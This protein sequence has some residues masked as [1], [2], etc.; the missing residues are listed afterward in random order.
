MRVVFLTHNYP[1]RAGDASGAFLATLA[2]ALVRAGVD[3]RVVAPSHHGE[4]GDETLDGVSVRR[5][6][7]ATAT[8]ETIAYGA[9]ATALRRPGGWTALAGLWRA[10]RR[11]AREELAA[12]ADLIHA[13]WWVP[14]GLATPAGAPLVLTS[15]GSDA[16]L[17]QRSRVARRLALPVYG[18]ARVVTTV[19]REL[20]GWIQAGASRYVGPA[21][22]Q[23]MPVESSGWPWST[24]GEGAVVI[25]R[26]VRQKR[27]DLALR[28]IAV[29]I[30][31]GHEIGLTVIGDGPERAALEQLAAE[32]GIASFVRFAGTVAPAAIP[33]CLAGADVLLFP[34]H[35][36]GF[37][38]AAA[39]ALMAGV[40][41][42]ACWDGGGILDVVPESGAGRLTLPAPDS[43]ADAVLDVLG[44]PDR[45]EMA[46]VTGESW[47]ARL[48]PDHVAARCI[49]W[50]EEA[51]RG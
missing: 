1:R 32:L 20:A 5:V 29:V 35:G 15:H 6:R 27:V 49:E 9:M 11:A 40:P 36:E 19:S 16:A 25:A 28:A 30:S 8:K 34:A 7:Y 46:R 13:H 45:L 33:H 18:R 38:L 14:A 10:L 23:P 37:G 51:L 44:D 50:Y 43:I 3:V 26:L 47:R 31:C 22:I 12:G 24:G 4:T 39:E 2:R 42:V 17:L 21:H 41:V 48:A